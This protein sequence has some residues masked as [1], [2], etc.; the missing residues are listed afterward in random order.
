MIFR[1][2]QRSGHGDPWAIRDHKLREVTDPLGLSPEGQ[3][4]E[5]VRTDQ[6]KEF[7]VWAFLA[8]GFQGLDAVVRAGAAGL[9]FRDGE[10]GVAGDGQ[11]DHFEP[12]MGA[13]AITPLVWRLARD[14][15]PDLVKVAGFP[16][17]LC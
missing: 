13:G 4:N 8:E 7:V 2:G 15:E 12:V 10:V 1:E 17:N 11:S 3:V 5:A 14:D 16:A 6:E 9:D